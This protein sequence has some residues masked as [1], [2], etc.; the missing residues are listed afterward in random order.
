M[1]H[2]GQFRTEVVRPAL[3]VIDAWSEAAEN[4]VV[5]TAVQESRLTYL[6]QFNGGPA[7]GVF[8][9]EP[10]T[11]DDVWANYI[12]FRPDLSAKVHSVLSSVPLLHDQLE[13]NLMYAAIMCRVIYMRATEALPDAANLPAL[14][15][16]WKR[17]YNT[18]GGA[19]TPDEWVRHYKEVGA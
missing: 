6:R 3:K 5:G 14:G 9:I 8:Q 4:L 1:I 10:A 13:T 12:G 19:G 2:V 15:G 18:A 17:H 7:R 16:Y 11:H